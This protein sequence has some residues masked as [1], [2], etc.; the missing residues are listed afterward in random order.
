MKKLLLA[1]MVGVGVSLPHPLPL[2]A[3]EAET[4]FMINLAPGRVEVFV[5]CFMYDEIPSS[6]GNPEPCRR[7]RPCLGAV[8]PRC[9]RRGDQQL[10]HLQF[11]ILHD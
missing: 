5:N 6:N 3:S 1:R 8:R 2:T 9:P 10:D 4:R 11:L 7:K